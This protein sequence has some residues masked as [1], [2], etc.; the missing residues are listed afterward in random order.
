[1][2]FSRTDRP[3]K[4]I[5]VDGR[6]V[7]VHDEALSS[8][9]I[10]AAERNPSNYSL[11]KTESNGNNQMIPPGKRI[12]VIDGDTFETNLNGEGGN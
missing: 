11:V 8:D 4:R 3:R 10:R 5:I 2:G 12:A 6:S 7:E 1:M 9:I